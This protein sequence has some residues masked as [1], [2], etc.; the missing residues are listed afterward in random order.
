MSL[1]EPAAR[2]M[3]TSSA[4]LLNFASQILV[5]G[6]GT[7]TAVLVARLLGPAGKGVVS[8]VMLSAALPVT[9]GALGVPMYHGCVAGRGEFSRAELRANAVFYALTGSALIALIAVLVRWTGLLSVSAMQLG[10][11]LAA[12]P[13]GLAMRNFA[14]IFQGEGRFG[15]YN[16]LTLVMWL[17]ILTGTVV[18]GLT[19]GGLKSVLAA[20][21]LGY[22][23]A[24]GLGWWMLRGGA[25]QRPS[26]V[27]LRASLEFG[28]AVWCVQLV[29]EANLRFDTYVAAFVGGAAGAGYYSVA[30][31]ITNLLFYLPA[32]IGTGTLPRMATETPEEAARLTGIGCRISLWSSAALAV[33]VAFAARPL[34]HFLF[35]PAFDPAVVPLLL[36][37]P[38]IVVYALA[39]VTTSYFYGQAGRPMLNGLVALI[40]LV[41]GL[42]ASAILA[43]RYGLAGVATA[44]SIGRTVAMGVNLWLFTR[45]SRCPLIDALLP[46]PGDLAVLLAPLRRL[47]PEARPA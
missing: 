15:E 6:A 35:G 1:P 46:R 22:V 31:S 38:G 8:L 28:L 25:F 12:V 29:G 21:W 9:F 43:P 10:W 16:A 13:A 41:V 36:L 47:W 7:A 24:A 5:L 19:V 18:L 33:F 4:A 44:V 40:S 45:L 2:P 27:L 34:I 32:A 23:V 42:A 30:V 14:G 39:H 11:V 17:V 20:W 37:L 3:A 26:K